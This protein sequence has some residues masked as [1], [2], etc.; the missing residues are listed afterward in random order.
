MNQSSGVEFSPEPRAGHL[1]VALDGGMADAHGLGR[2]LDGEAAEELQLDDARLVGVER[3]EAFERLVDAEQVEVG[4]LAE[5]FGLGERDG[6]LPAAP[7]LGLYGA[8]V[9]NQ[10]A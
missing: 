4:A 5:A 7:L 1:P 9:V 8:R 6:K 2:L 10:D 3:R